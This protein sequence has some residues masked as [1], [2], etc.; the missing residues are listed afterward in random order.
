MVKAVFDHLCGE[1]PLNHFTVGIHDDLTH[2][3][4]PWE[5]DFVTEAPGEVRAVFYGLGSD[6]TVG[7]NKSTIK[8]I[9]ESTDLHAQGYFVYDSKKSGS[10]TVSHLRFGPRPIRS[11]YL[12][13]RP[14]L[15][16]CHQWDFLGRFDLLAGLETGG[17][18]LL[19]SPYPAEE[20]WRRLPEAM[21]TTIRAKQLKVWIINASQVAMEAGMG[22]HINTVM[23]ACF[24]AVSGVLPREEAIERIRTAIVK[25][26]GRKGRRSWP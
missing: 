21:R 5:N 13:Q 14:T 24:F 1:D 25:T 26:Y 17:I 15:V 9:G 2:R 8:I 4:L 11:T 16:A 23:Q 18:L 7:A 12:I 6:G 20:S 22:F 10:V 19:N 3:S